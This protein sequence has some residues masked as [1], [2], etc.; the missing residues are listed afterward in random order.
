MSVIATKAE[1]IRFALSLLD[2][3][4]REMLLIEDDEVRHREALRIVDER[5]KLEAALAEE[6][7]ADKLFALG[8]VGDA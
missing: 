2:D 3:D 1:R 6:R 7:A 4:E 8:V 5:R